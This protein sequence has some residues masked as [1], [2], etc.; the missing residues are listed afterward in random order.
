M[1]IADFNQ[2]TSEQA[3]Q[4][5]SDCCSAS[6]WISVLV[7]ARPYNNVTELKQAADK[8]WQSMQEMDFFTSL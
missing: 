7:K 3:E 2:L 4:Y 1:K 5:L 6:K 8:L